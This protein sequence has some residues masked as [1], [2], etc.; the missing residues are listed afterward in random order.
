MGKELGARRK[1]KD[2]Y[3]EEG[4]LDFEK[5]YES[6]LFNLGIQRVKDILKRIYCC[7]DVPRKIH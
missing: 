5:V 4:Y 7:T 3:S 1:D 6:D 2:L